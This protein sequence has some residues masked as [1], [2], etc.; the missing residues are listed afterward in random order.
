M[1]WASVDDHAELAA[2]GGEG[3]L[4]LMPGVGLG[5]DEAH[6]LVCVRKDRLIVRP[7]GCAPWV[8][9]RPGPV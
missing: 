4:D 8:R 7:N 9:T 6:V 3:F 1:A 5:E 2:G